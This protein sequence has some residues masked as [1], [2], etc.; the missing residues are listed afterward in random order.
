[1]ADFKVPEL[2]E[3]IESAEITKLLVSEGDTIEKDQAVIELETGKA[4]VE[5]PCPFAGTVSKIHVK[6]GDEVKVGQAI[7]TVED[8]GAEEKAGEQAQGKKEEEQGKEEDKGKGEEEPREKEVEKNKQKETPPEKVREVERKEDE[9]PQEKEELEP[10]TPQT[11]EQE[12]EA[13]GVEEPSGM[14]SVPAAPSVRRFARELGID[15]KKVSGKGPHGRVSK[16]DVKAFA[17]QLAQDEAGPGVSTVPSLPDF[18]R[19]G[20]VERKDMNNIRRLTAE[21]MALCWRQVPHVTQ[22][23]RVDISELEELRKRF[24]KKVEKAGGKLTITAII[25]KV[26]ASAL[27]VF[28]NFNSSLD[29]KNEQIIYKKYCNIGLAI[30]TPRGL[31]VPVIR[32]VDRKNITQIAVEIVELAEKARNGKLSPDDFEGGTFTITNL[33]SIGGTHFTP[34]VNYPEVAILGVGRAFKE[35]CFSDDG[36]CKPRLILPLSLSYDHRIIDGADGARFTRW[37]AEALEEPLL[38]S[39]EG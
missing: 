12:K 34:I 2:G 32:D 13:A 16:E 31:L 4:T 6:E 28:P 33:G 7:L 23:D 26:V 37:T 14:P 20:E 18:G 17:K 25:L 27:K 5:V 24:L 8:E 21:H 36:I 29:I 22:F 15:I 38:L 1:M 39:L 9:Q 19:W 30:D 35:P 3:N 11:P 10:V